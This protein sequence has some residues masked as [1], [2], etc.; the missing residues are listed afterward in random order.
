MNIV[1]VR[2]PDI[3]VYLIP[4]FV[5]DGQTAVEV[6]MELNDRL[7]QKPDDTCV[8]LA[9]DKGYLKGVL[10]GYI[11]Q[12]YLFVWQARKSKDMDRPRLIFHCL[13]EWSKTRGVKK[14]RLVSH[15]KRIRRLYK[16]KYGFTHIGDGLMEKEYGK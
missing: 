5:E 8:M 2:H 12:D 13:C 16:R 14:A 4:W 1:R 11:E 10:V 7:R 9:I 6:G 15:D 3:S